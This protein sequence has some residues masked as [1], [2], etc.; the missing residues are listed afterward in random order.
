MADQV[1]AKLLDIAP[2]LTS[3][4]DALAFATHLYFISEGCVLVTDESKGMYPSNDWTL[5][6]CYV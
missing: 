4:V 2:T 3:T 6:L 5:K 1:L